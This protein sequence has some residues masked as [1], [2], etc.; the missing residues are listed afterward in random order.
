MRRINQLNVNNKKGEKRKKNEKSENGKKRRQIRGSR[1]EGDKLAER[2]REHLFPWNRG[3]EQRESSRLSLICILS[4]RGMPGRDRV[5]SRNRKRSGEKK[6]TLS[7]ARPGHLDTPT[8]LTSRRF[9]SFPTHLLPCPIFVPLHQFP[10]ASIAPPL[11]PSYPL[12][13]PCLFIR[14]IRFVG[15][16]EVSRGETSSRLGL[17]GSVQTI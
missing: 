14:C 11:P 12:R 15:L 16:R 8:Y 13:F 3:R 7:R 5:K 2:C 6:R 9:P 17:S 1:V 10:P 4:S